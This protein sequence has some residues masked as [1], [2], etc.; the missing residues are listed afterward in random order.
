LES[1]FVLE[2]NLLTTYTGHLGQN[3]GTTST[4]LLNTRFL[5]NKI[6]FQEGHFL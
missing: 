6:A 1:S 2:N 3:A 4:V 5:K